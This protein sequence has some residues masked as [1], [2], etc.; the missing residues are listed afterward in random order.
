M[1]AFTARRDGTTP[2]EFWV[3]EHSPVFTLG[4]K[5]K[6]EH[7]LNPGTIPVVRCDRGGQVT[8]HGPGQVVIYLLLDLERMSLGVRALI[9]LIEDAV[10]ALLADYGIAAEARPKAPACTS[11][12][13]RSR[14]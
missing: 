2:D 4:L 7:L 12:A 5:A 10:I 13:A 6:T 1:Q 8:Y 9:S 3:V 14:P 11:K